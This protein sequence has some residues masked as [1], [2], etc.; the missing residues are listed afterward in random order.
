MH[1]PNV[2]KAH[3]HIGLL[4]SF[5]WLEKSIPPFPKLHV[6]KKLWLILVM[7]KKKI[8]QQL[9][10]SGCVCVGGIL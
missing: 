8:K 4:S 6:V 5:S 7:Q 9:K 3:W 10:A 1:L 2:P